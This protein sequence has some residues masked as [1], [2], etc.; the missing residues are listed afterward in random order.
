MPAPTILREDRSGR[1]TAGVAARGM[2]GALAMALGACAPLPAVNSPLVQHAWLQYTESGELAARAVMADA[3][4]ASPE[5]CPEL[6]WSGGHARMQLRAGAQVHA[7]RPDAA[8][9]DNKAAVFA[10]PTCELPW[11]VGAPAAKIG[12]VELTLAARD[13]RR[14]VL[15]GDTGC[16]LKASEHAFQDCNEPTRWPFAAVARSAAALRPDLVIH[17]G[18]L[19]YRESPCPADRAGCQG[20]PWGYGMDTWSA[21]FFEPARPLLAAAPWLFVRGNHESCSRAGVGWF[22]MLDA[23]AWSAQRSCAAPGQDAQADFS[24]PFAVRIAADTQLIVFD[25]SF[26]PGR[27][28][29]TESASFQRYQRMLAQVDRLARQVPHSFFLNHHPV[30]A[31]AGSASGAPKP[32]NAALQSVMAAAHPGRLLV[33]GIDLVLNGHV[34][35][36]E[37][38]D[39]SSAHPATWVS[40]NG[41]SQMEGRVDPGL[42]LAAQPAPGA[43]VQTFITQGGFGFATLD[44]DGDDWRLT[45]WGVA[46]EAIVSCRLNA[47][48]LQCD[49]RP[50]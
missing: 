17:L 46:G 24:E 11:P 1:R 36:F 15:L 26:A 48:H 38:L 31:F 27:A 45:E 49:P 39:F 9:P 8:Q 13:I 21:D 3:D 19:H 41:G 29:P 20:S 47:R 18:D 42:A 37:A 40:G 6:Q 7:P 10:G 43:V 44:H 34:H 35:A 25:S 2:L 23:G 14:I 22:R 5:A 16:R 50:P 28:L 32:G 33:E 30:L 4:A 12:S